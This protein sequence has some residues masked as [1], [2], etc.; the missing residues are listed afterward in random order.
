[1]HY[2]AVD[3]AYNNSFKDKVKEYEDMTNVNNYKASLQNN[4]DNYRK[5]NSIV[6]PDTFDNYSDIE[7]NSAQAKP[8]T[9]AFFTAQGDYSSHGPYYG[10]K[11]SELKSDTD[12]DNVSQSETISNDSTMTPNVKKKSHGYYTNAFIHSLEN[13]LDLNSLDSS[14]YNSVYDHV[15]KCKECKYGINKKLKMNSQKIDLNIQP[16][17]KEIE[18]DKKKTVEYFTF[19]DIGYNIKEIIIILLIGIIIVFVLDLLVKIGKKMHT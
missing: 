8:I 10:T 16:K 6:L 3:E 12:I 13:D 7:V 5:D 19:T 11:I 18:A 1:M 17:I 15:K 2:C 9:P 14:N 4:L